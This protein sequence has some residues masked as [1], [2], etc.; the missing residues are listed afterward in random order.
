MLYPTLT[1]PA[2]EKRSVDADVAKS[3]IERNLAREA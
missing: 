2:G 3:L 1:G